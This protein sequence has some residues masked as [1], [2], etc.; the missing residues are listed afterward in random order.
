MIE[1]RCFRC[2]T[3]QADLP[4]EDY[5]YALGYCL[6]C[7]EVVRSGNPFGDVTDISGEVQ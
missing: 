4:P 6:P 1:E 5:D 3:R 7:L 2:G